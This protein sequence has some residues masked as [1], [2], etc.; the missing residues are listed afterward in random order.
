MKILAFETEMIVCHIARAEPEQAR[1]Q[2]VIDMTER[3]FED[4]RRIER[5]FWHWN[6]TILGRLREN[7]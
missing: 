7:E 3:E 6:N 2:G 1:V 5:A 4:F